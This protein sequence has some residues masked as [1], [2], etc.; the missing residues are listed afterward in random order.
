M[1]SIHMTDAYMTDLWERIETLEQRL[2]ANP[3]DRGV[4]M[5]LDCCL[6]NYESKSKLLAQSNH[7][8][9]IST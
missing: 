6:R 2:I 9:Y 8:L 5:L 3:E 4:A 7:L 1:G